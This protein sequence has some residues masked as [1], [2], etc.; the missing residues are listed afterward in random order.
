[1]LE[2]FYWITVSYFLIIVLILVRILY[3]EYCEHVKYK[4]EWWRNNEED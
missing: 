3:R 2:L 1:L 4:E